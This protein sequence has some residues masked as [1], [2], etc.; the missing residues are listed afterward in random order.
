[1]IALFV[2]IIHVLT[3]IF[4]APFK[5]SYLLSSPG[6]PCSHHGGRGDFGPHSRQM[7]RFYVPID[8]L[9]N[10]PWLIVLGSSLSQAALHLDTTLCCSDLEESRW[11]SR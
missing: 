11:R 4:F 1:M 9:G 6:A 5:V 7:L 8:F 10:N 3:N 2:L